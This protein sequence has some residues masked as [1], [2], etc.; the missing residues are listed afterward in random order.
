MSGVAVVSTV[1]VEECGVGAL[2]SIEGGDEEDGVNGAVGRFSGVGGVK[3][4]E[5]E[6]EARVGR[7][8]SSDCGASVWTVHVECMS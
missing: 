8:A 1:G 2:G 7:E 6:R 5:G 3:R 4:E